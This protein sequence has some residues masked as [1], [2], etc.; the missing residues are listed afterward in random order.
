MGHGILRLELRKIKLSGRLCPILYEVLKL[1]VVKGSANTH[2]FDCHLIAPI[3][4]SQCERQM[5]SGEYD[6]HLPI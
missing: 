1:L 4:M 6:Q 3:L 2:V 5:S